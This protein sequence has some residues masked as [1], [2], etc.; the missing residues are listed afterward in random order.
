MLNQQSRYVRMVVVGTEAQSSVTVRPLNIYL[1]CAST[2]LVSTVLCLTCS[3]GCT[4]VRVLAS[5]S[6]SGGGGGG[7]GGDRV[8]PVLLFLRV[9]VCSRPPYPR[10]AGAAPLLCGRFVQP[11]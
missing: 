2:L 11:A 3:S 5:S 10:R 9:L 6:S 7:G 4:H 8:P 1:Q